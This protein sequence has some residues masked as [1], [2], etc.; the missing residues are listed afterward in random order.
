[1]SWNLCVYIYI[2]MYSDE[3]TTYFTKQEVLKTTF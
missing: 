3:D 1:M 2:Y